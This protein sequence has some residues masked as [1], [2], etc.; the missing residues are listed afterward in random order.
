MYGAFGIG[1]KTNPPSS[2]QALGGFLWQEF[3]LALSRFRPLSQEKKITMATSPAR[4]GRIASN[5]PPELVSKNTISRH[6]LG[7]NTW[8]FGNQPKNIIYS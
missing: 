5:A 4:T 3:I 2:C 1:K 8:Q 6:L 7:E